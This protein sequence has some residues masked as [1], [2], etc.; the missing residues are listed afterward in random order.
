MDKRITQ[1]TDVLER[2]AKI[3]KAEAFER[4][5]DSDNFREAVLAMKA[6]QVDPSTISRVLRQWADSLDRG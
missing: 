1:G 4:A 3:G 6:A 5:V 2:L